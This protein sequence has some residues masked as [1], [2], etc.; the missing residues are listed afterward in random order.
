MAS[1]KRRHNRTVQF[2]TTLP[3]IVDVYGQSGRAGAGWQG[4]HKLPG[5][6]CENGDAGAGVLRHGVL[7]VRMWD[8]VMKFAY[9][10]TFAGEPRDETPAPPPGKPAPALP[11]LPACRALF[12]QT[13]TRIFQTGKRI[14]RAMLAVFRTG[15]RQRLAFGDHVPGPGP[16]LAA[17]PKRRNRRLSYPP[18]SHKACLGNM[19]RAALIARFA[20]ACLRGPE[21]AAPPQPACFGLLGDFSNGGLRPIATSGTGYQTLDFDR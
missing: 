13:G 5:E 1:A 16:H 11:R 12:R 18:P 3:I 6:G 21:W 17:Q 15:R 14:F 20:P 8:G 4:P 2:S 9:A 19:D 10:W 7:R